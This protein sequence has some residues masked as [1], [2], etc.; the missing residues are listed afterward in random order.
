MNFNRRTD[1]SPSEILHTSRVPRHQYRSTIRRRTSP[2]NQLIDPND[3]VPYIIE[4]GLHFR[5]RLLKVGVSLDGLHPRMFHPGIPAVIAELCGPIDP[6]DRFLMITN[7]RVAE[8]LAHRGP[9]IALGIR[10][11]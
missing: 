6:L 9:M 2:A 11:E 4:I 3:I 8:G 10:L 1:N 7:L 5:D